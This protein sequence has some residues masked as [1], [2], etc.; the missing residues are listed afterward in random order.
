M[1]YLD[2][3][4]WL[5]VPCEAAVKAA[6]PALRA[7]IAR[8]LIKEHGLTQQKTAELL[9]VTQAAI[10]YYTK[11]V[12]GDVL[13]VERI[14]HVR[15]RSKKI[16]TS[17]VNRELSPSELAIKVCELCSIVRLSGTMCPL[18]KRIE[19]ALDSASC[20]VC[21][22]VSEFCPRPAALA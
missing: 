13:N 5:F 16:A 12:R 14:R 8:D 21:R 10:S 2:G 19:P 1:H 7:M 9:N 4:I 17:L 18:C 6:I 15:A 22:T 20:G 3:G 11:K